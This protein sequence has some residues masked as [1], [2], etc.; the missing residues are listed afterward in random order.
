[1]PNQP[2]PLAFK[3]ALSFSVSGPKGQGTVDLAAT[4]QNGIWSLTGLKLK[5]DGQDNWIDLLHPT[6]AEIEGYRRRA[7]FAVSVPLQRT[8]V[9]PDVT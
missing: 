6:N 5:M 2:K 9:A 7:S 3:A 4:R 1:M 8:V